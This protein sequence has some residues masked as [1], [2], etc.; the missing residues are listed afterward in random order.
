MKSTIDKILVVGIIFILAGLTLADPTSPVGT[1]REP[2][3]SGR[4]QGLRR[5]PNP[6]DSSGNDIITG[7]VSGDKY[8][9]GNVPYRSTTNF[10]GSSSST[11]LDNFLRRS[12][13][14]SEYDYNSGRYKP[15]YSPS[16][17]VSII[18]PGRSGVVNAPNVDFSGRVVTGTSATDATSKI[19]NINPDHQLFSNQ[20]RPIE[21]NSQEVRRTIE[22]DLNT[23]YKNLQTEDGQADEK[24]RNVKPDLVMTRDQI[25]TL[26]NELKGKQ[27]IVTS[28]FDL[29]KIDEPQQAANLTEVDM[30]IAKVDSGEQLD[31]YDQMRMEAVGLGA[32]LKVKQEA[33]KQGT[34]TQEESLEKAQMDPSPEKIVVEAKTHKTFATFKN[35]KFNQHIRLAEEYLKEGKYYRAS[36]AYS[37]AEFYKPGDPVVYA[38]KSQALFAAGEFMSSAYYLS[39]A[40]DEFPGIVEIKVDIVAIVGDK[41]V[42]ESRASD[43]EELIKEFNSVEL[44][45]LLSYVYYQMGRLPRAKELI[46]EAYETNP[47][48]GVVQAIRSGIDEA[49]NKRGQ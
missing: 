11:S 32:M 35:D 38:G 6:I 19:M 42:L 16:G 25:E 27:Q 30:L 28:D 17:S 3:T 47:D 9:R 36:S 37:L 48:L 2:A 20:V 15:Y 33:V 23:R 43:V 7:N 41:D 5:S 46:D 26:R 12:A 14:S 10:G 49:L 22:A 31:I 13:G 8:F 44:K 29:Q 1:G 40:V 39:M 24:I 4:S 21:L 45:Y 34:L 18:R